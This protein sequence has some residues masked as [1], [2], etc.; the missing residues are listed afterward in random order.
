MNESQEEQEQDE[1]QVAE[2]Y[3]RLGMEYVKFERERKREIEVRAG[4]SIA[5]IGVLLTL[6]LEML[7]L[8]FW[9]KPESVAELV[10]FITIT[11]LSNLPIVTILISL[12]F[13]FK[14]IITKEYVGVDLPAITDRELEKTIVITHRNIFKSHQ[15]FIDKNRVINQK[16]A[17]RFNIGIKWMKLTIVCVIITYFI[18]EILTNI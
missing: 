6:T 14:V 12:Y 7:S 5:L 13:F 11:L 10:G 18:K 2:I 4:I 16:K 3:S 9:E 15:D 8:S 17:E 1:S